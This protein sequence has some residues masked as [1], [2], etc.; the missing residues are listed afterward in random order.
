MK[1]N[2]KNILLPS[3]ALWRGRGRGWVRLLL[4]L[5]VA[6]L[7]QPLPAQV[8]PDNGYTGGTAIVRGRVTNIAALGIPPEEIDQGL[9]LRYSSPLDSYEGTTIPLR[10]DSTGHFEVRAQLANT[11][12]A[13]LVMQ[14]VVLEPGRT[15]DVTID[16]ATWA[17]TFAGDDTQL[18]TEL[19]TYPL[20][21]FVWDTQLMDTKTDAEALSAARTE[22]AR[23]DSLEAALYAEHPDLS[24]R[25]RALH[26]GYVRNRAASYLVQR[27]FLS[28][29]VRQDDGTLWAYLRT[30]TDELPRP[31]TLTDELAYVLTNYVSSL[32]DPPRRRGL[33]LPYIRTALDIAEE[34]YAPRSDAE[35]RERMQKISELRTQL[36]DYERI[37]PTATDSALQAHPALQMVN[38]LFRQAGDPVLSDV[39][40]GTAVD[41]RMMEAHLG[42]MATLTQLPAD[43][44]EP[45][46]GAMLYGLMSQT[47]APLSPAMQRLVRTHLRG[48][49][50]KQQILRRSDELAGFAASL[51]EAE[52]TGCLQDSAPF[53]G[54][55]DGEEIWKKIVEPLRGRVVFVDVWGTWCGPCKADLKHHTQALHSALAGLPVSYVYLCNRS[56]DDAWRSCIAEYGL[57]LPHSLHY[58]LP[59]EQQA[60]LEKYLQVEYFPTYILFRPDGTRATTPDQQPRPYDPASVRRQVEVAMG[61]N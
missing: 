11:T 30:L 21:G 37:L 47:H 45:A 57:V 59:L 34:R 52:E 25:Y 6:I 39:V 31:Y 14:Q 1:R 32:L 17:S 58:N 27:R 40:S 12:A 23:L 5:F 20:P 53:A 8:F 56:K 4:V 13:V 33:N 55:T 54:M 18:N 46:I 29:D 10:P 50:Y 15:Y 36:D 35:A 48:D 3:L 28:P 43:L 2:L 7:S 22:I 42:Q 44:R 16:G 51:A 49:Y 60:A 9:A 41:E 26:H 19:A 38:E 61:K 24:P